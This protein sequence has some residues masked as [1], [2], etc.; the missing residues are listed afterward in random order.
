MIH[1]RKQERGAT[2]V[3]VTMFMVALFGFAALS[4]DVGNVLREQRKEQTGTDAGAL[5]GVAMLTNN[6]QPSVNSVIDIATALANANGVS[7]NEI[8]AGARSGFPGEVQVGVWRNGTFVANTTTNGR[9]TAVRVPSR[10]T[11]TMNFARVV[12]ISQ[13][14]P[15]VS[16]VAMIDGAGNAV[17]VIPFGVSA[18]EVTNKAVGATMDLN[19]GSIGSGKQGKVDLGTYQNTGAWEADMTTNGCNCTVSLGDVPIIPGNA[20]VRQ[21]FQALGTGAIFAMP[22]IDN[23]SFSGGSGIATIIGFVTVKIISFTGTGSNWSATVEFL[24]VVAGTAGGGCPPPCT[25]ARALVE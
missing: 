1:R 10:R 22:V 23:Q 3:L 20:Q 9:Y 11:V 6:P 14:T 19:D 12:G 25:Q 17:N 13:M 8:T 21:S 7:S 4:L 2:L 18:S 24:G 15:S 5:A 16:S